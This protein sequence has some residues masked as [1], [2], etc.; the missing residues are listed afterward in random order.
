MA[1]LF[2]ELRKAILATNMDLKA[3]GNFL[4]KTHYPNNNNNHPSLTQG[5]KATATETM[6]LL[7]DKV[8]D[9]HQSQDQKI[10]NLELELQKAKQS[11]SSP[12]PH[13]KRSADSIPL[14]PS[15]KTKTDH[16]PDDAYL[17]PTKE[18]P[19]ATS[20]PAG[21]HHASIT[22]WLKSLQATMTPED[23]KHMDKYINQVTKA[24][25]TLDKTKRP[26]L[27]DLA[28]QWGLPCQ[29]AVNYPEAALIKVSAASAWM[30]THNTA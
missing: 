14:S 4:H 6:K 2:Q 3:L 7:Q 22:K 8:K 23:T 13:R 1:T 12:D 26:N 16:T 17:H 29:D 25:S 11:S 20:A 18:R 9:S 19:L 5:A 27:Q 30:V 15:K 10:K 21:G 28:S 24:W